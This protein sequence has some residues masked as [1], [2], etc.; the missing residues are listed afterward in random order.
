MAWLAV[1]GTLLGTLIGA[2]ATLAAQQIAAR[3]ADKR[4]Q[5]QR[6]SALRLERKNQIDAFL[7]A[8]QEAERIAGDRDQF[9]YGTI[10]RTSHNLWAH[11][12]RLALICS[13]EL[14][15]PLDELVNALHTTL[16]EGAPEGVPVWKYVA[17]QTWRFREAARREVEWA[18]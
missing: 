4:E 17:D 10:T 1:L 16:W 7:D 5:L 13:A 12:K 18:E 8:A 11:H 6:R 3:A 15:S 9:D 2:I 14:A